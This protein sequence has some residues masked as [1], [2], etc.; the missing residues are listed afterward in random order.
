MATKHTIPTRR[1]FLRSGPQSAPDPNSKQLAAVRAE[2]RRAIPGG[3][4]ARCGHD[5]GGFVPGE[6]RLS[7]SLKPV[8]TVAVR[9]YP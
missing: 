4:G 8:P 7:A 2:Y 1:R 6:A 5:P 3:H 9:A